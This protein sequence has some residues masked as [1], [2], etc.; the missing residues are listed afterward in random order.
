M[1]ERRYERTGKMEELEE[2]IQVAWQAANVTPKD[3]P[4]LAAMLSGL[5]YKEFW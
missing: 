2:A 1:L 3:H 4:D 5:D